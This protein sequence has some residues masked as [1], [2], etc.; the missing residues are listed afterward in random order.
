ML[1]IFN[2]SFTITR[3]ERTDMPATEYE[4]T[5]GWK[6]EAGSGPLNSAQL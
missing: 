5:I 3:N 1:L 4:V 6:I 2:D